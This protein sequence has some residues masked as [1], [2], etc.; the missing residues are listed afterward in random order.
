RSQ[1]KTLT[2][3]RK[4]ISDTSILEV[5]CPLDHGRH[6][7]NPELGATLGTLCA[8][9]VELQQTVLSFL[10]INSLLVFRRVS[11]SAM[12]LVNALIDYHKV[13]TTAPDAIRMALAIRTHHYHTITELFEALCVREC[14]DCGTLTHYIDLVTLRRVCLSLN[15]HCNHTLAP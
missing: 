13:V 11:R 10:D 5:K 6:D 9:P 2:E 7:A 1:Q 15:R 12:G 4:Q 8:L 14:A 3:L